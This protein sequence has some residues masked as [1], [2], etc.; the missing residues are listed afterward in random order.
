VLTPGFSLSLASPSIPQ[1]CWEERA[2]HSTGPDLLRG[3]PWKVN[4]LQVVVIV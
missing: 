1:H 4:P 3:N 2:F